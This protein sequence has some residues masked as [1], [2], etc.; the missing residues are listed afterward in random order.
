MVCACGSVFVAGF[1]EIGRKRLVF[2]DQIDK[3]ER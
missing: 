1:V 2:D 3:A